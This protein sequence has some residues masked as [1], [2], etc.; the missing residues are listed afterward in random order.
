VYF[1]ERTISYKVWTKAFGGGKS[2]FAVSF[3]K[4]WTSLFMYKKGLFWENS[5]NLASGPVSSIRSKRKASGAKVESKHSNKG[6]KSSKVITYVNETEIKFLD[7]FLII[8]L[9]SLSL[10]PPL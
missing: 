8:F 10:L 9:F 1:K 2:E 6:H 4:L 5:K 3:S 7:A